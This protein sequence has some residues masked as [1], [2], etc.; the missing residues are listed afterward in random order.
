MT[1]R[2]LGRT[3][4][5][6]CFI[7]KF[8]ASHMS[9]CDGSFAD[10][11]HECAD[12]ESSA[13]AILVARLLRRI[14]I[15]WPVFLNS[16]NSF[17]IS[18]TS[19][20]SFFIS[21]VWVHCEAKAANWL[22][23]GDSFWMSLPWSLSWICRGLHSFSETCQWE[24][25]Q[26]AFQDLNLGLQQSEERWLA[27]EGNSWWENREGFVVHL[28][29]S[30][31][32]RFFFSWRCWR[33]KV[34]R[35]S[36]S[37]AHCMFIGGLFSRGEAIIDD[38]TWELL[39]FLMWFSK[40]RDYRSLDC[41]TSKGSKASSYLF[42]GLVRKRRRG[43]GNGSFVGHDNFFGRSGGCGL[44]EGDI[45]VLLP[46]GDHVLYL[47]VWLSRVLVVE[48]GDKFFI[49]GLSFGEISSDGKMRRSHSVVSFKVQRMTPGHILI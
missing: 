3:V 8:G 23:I 21:L 42:R 38:S 26:V 9:P 17:F 15:L 12:W 6:S 27:C 16:S 47:I 35:E 30:R 39:S 28:H 34:F 37:Y 45:A 2:F 43:L 1:K 36:R 31:R 41:R 40:R 18:L 33:I 20:W 32:S 44:L 10:K 22:V 13:L 29:W 25:L 48:S 11:W 19:V 49:K 7:K 5:L 4:Q 24:D 14:S 46:V